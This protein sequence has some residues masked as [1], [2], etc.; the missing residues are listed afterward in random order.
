MKYSG[1]PAG[2][3]PVWSRALAGMTVKSADGPEK[4]TT[5]GA[6]SPLYICCLFSAQTCGAMYDAPAA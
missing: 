6:G 1:V 4:S 5:C 2:G 3:V